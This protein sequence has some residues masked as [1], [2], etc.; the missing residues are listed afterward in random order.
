[1]NGLGGCQDGPTYLEDEGGEPDESVDL[2][3]VSK[4][5]LF[6]LRVSGGTCQNDADN[7]R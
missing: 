3:L 1:M 4:R 6:W 2:S 7:A 5:V